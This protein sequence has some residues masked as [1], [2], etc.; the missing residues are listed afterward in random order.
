MTDQPYT[1]A[2]LRAEA[3]M[4]YDELTTD[5]DFMG[6]GESMQDTA[7]ESTH[8]DPDAENDTGR[9]WGELLPYQDDDGKAYA[10]AQEKIHDLISGAADLGEWAVNL[11]ADGLEPE[12]RAL[13]PDAGVRIHFAFDPTVP[14]DVQRAWIDGIH[15]AIREGL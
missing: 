12:G 13:N 9:T 2:D 4:Q 14:D 6:V 5:P 8:P 10:A 3:A 7:V 11:G 15:H 1:D